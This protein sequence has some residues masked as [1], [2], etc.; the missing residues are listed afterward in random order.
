MEGFVEL[1]VAFL[2]ALKAVTAKSLIVTVVQ[3]LTVLFPATGSTVSVSTSGTLQTLPAA[4]AVT[5]RLTVA[6]APAVS[7]SKSQTNCPLVNTKVP[8]LLALET[9]DTRAGSVSTNSAFEASCGP[10]LVTTKL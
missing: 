5:V 1:K 2:G 6:E 10:L 4:V 3:A 9:Y 8:A 7:V